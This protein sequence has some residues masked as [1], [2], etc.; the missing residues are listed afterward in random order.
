MGILRGV[1]LDDPKEIKTIALPD[2]P[3]WK[4][5]NMSDKKTQIRQ[6]IAEFIDGQKAEAIID[7]LADEFERH[8]NLAQ[9]I[10]NQLT[11]STATGRFL[12]KRLG[13][14]GIQRPPEIGMSDYA[15]RE[16]GIKINSQK[17]LIDLIHS[18]LETFYGYTAVRAH[19]TCENEEP[20]NLDD[21][22]SLIYSLEDGQERTLTFKTSDFANINQAS[23]QE[24][25][26]VITRHIRSYKLGGF[27]E[28]LLDQDTQKTFVRVFG[29]AKG[30]YSKVLMLGGEANVRLN[31]PTKIPTA[32]ANN[33]TM[34]QVTKTKGNTY[35]FRWIG[36]DSPN[37]SVVLPGSRVMMYGPDFKQNELEGTHLVTNVR[38]PLV[39]PD[40]TSGWFEVEMDR[41]LNLRY[42]PAGV[43]P[44]TNIPSSGIYYSK[45]VQ[46]TSEYDLVFMSE[47]Q[48]LP[49]NQ[50]RYSLA[51]ETARNLLKIYMPATT[52]I[53][54]RDLA[55]GAFLHIGKKGD[56][57]DGIFGSSTDSKYK[58]QIINDYAIRYYEPEYD[59]YGAGGTIDYPSN[60]G[61]PIEI[62]KALRENFYTTVK[63][64]IP[65]G[66]VG[67]VDL[68][69]R[70]MFDDLVTV[71]VDY[72]PTDQEEWEG[73]FVIDPAVEYNLMDQYVTSRRKVYA[74]D[75]LTSLTVDGFLDNTAGLL[76]FDL[77]TENEESGVPYIGAQTVGAPTI[78]NIVSIS[79]SGNTLTV[80]TDA[81]H[82][83]ILGSNVQVAGTINFNGQYAV[84]SI[85]SPTT[86]IATRPTSF[87]GAETVGSTWVVTTVVQTILVLDPSYTFQKS[88]DIGADITR[89]S[90]ATAY[91]PDPKGSDY[92]FFITGTADARVYAQDI[93]QQIVAFGIGLEIV[94][95]YPSDVGLGNQGGSAD[96]NDALVSDKVGIW[97]V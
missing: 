49:Y 52:N 58:V 40:L 90:E 41:A 9:S 75:A 22:Q 67:S 91:I 72:A 3:C 61:D 64:V 26:D 45:S 96:E 47:Y 89:I 88:H 1:E 54:A 70:E 7:T 42:T 78:V 93:I 10:T 83:A 20:Y 57:F 34:W 97:G 68:Y 15:F 32:T 16:L 43:S 19:V 65:H 39:S 29:G 46:L 31:F 37:L 4:E 85:P 63:C 55:G 17:K 86:Y 38:P 82:G 62:D 25:A 27:A 12:D 80:N 77:N 66:I 30:P 51:W 50:P 23:A 14:V 95:V 69:G 6:H 5:K 18:V 28:T 74:G 48:A 8:T 73:P 92:S 53:V 11:I 13:D 79:Q 44:G 60:S 94:I 36:N 56:D 84:S 21:G 35:R 24:I 76:V 2:K 87:V 59:N 71:N 33:D 81:P